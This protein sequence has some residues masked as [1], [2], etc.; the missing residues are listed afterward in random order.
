M[1]EGTRLFRS[2]ELEQFVK[3][4]PVD[5]SLLIR[6]IARLAAE[7]DRR[8]MCGTSVLVGR[9]IEHLHVYNHH[10]P[11]TR[12]RIEGVLR[13]FCIVF[14]DLDPG[15]ISKPLVANWISKQA[16][17]PSTQAWVALLIERCVAFG[18]KRA[19]VRWNQ[20]DGL[21]SQVLERLCEADV[22]T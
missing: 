12:K 22:A 3:K 10:T 15:R 16:W 2:Q 6:N 19:G 21:Q 11:R 7:E 17:A 14:G 8:N 9:Y 5:H 18:V 4:Y 20:L 1:Y 13:R